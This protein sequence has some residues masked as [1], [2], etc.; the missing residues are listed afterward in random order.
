MGIHKDREIIVSVI[1]PIRNEEKYIEKCINSVLNQDYPLEN[2]EVIFVDGQS[3][4][5]TKEIIL[6]CI[7]QYPNIIR[8]VENPNKTVP[9]AMNIGIRYSSGKYLIRLDAHSEYSNDYISKCITTIEKTGADNVGGLAITK[10]RGKIGKSFAKVLSSKFGVG[11]SGFR[12]NSPSGYVDTVPFGA[13]KRETFEKYGFYDER[14][15]RNQDYEL[16]YRIRKNG[17][18]IYLNSNIKLTYYCRETLRAILS[19][20]YNNGK[21]NVLTAKL[22]PG[23]MSVRHF[24][25]LIFMLSLLVFPILML[26]IPIMGWL[27]ILELALYFSLSL[28]FSLKLSSKA[29]S[30]PLL[31]FLFPVFHISYGF[32]SLVGLIRGLHYA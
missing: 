10:G 29:A 30:I 7:Q 14:L 4:D 20:S 24:I 23:S 21:W 19:Q 6:S 27:F 15:I 18:K 5:R 11:N 28:I 8:I 13:F 2:I 31:F 9:Y 12:T 26:F 22:C 32:G 17:G 3:K 16:N 1:I 25:P